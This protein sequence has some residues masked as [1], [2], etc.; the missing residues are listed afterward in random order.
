MSQHPFCLP[1]AT[2]AILLGSFA[3]CL[4]TAT[5]A[6]AAQEEIAVYYN[7]RPPYL[8]S[9]ADGSV[10]GLTGTPAARAFHAAGV[11]FKWVL[12]PTNRQKQ[13]L[14]DTQLPGC[15]VGWF[16]NAERERFAKYTKPIYQDRPTVGL[17]T[18]GNAIPE[19]TPLTMVLAN[20]QL[21]ILVK[22]GYSYGPYIDQLLVG[23]RS[24]L[25]V[26]TMENVEMM[27]MIA[28][29]LA[30][31]MFAAEEE[32]AAL[33]QQAGPSPQSFRILHFTDVPQ[34]ERRYI[35]CNKAVPNHVIQRLNAAIPPLG[36]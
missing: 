14:M 21:R 1:H 3:C 13:A 18:T 34:G 23:K 5:Q 17:A 9:E 28:R 8:V 30:D 35:M 4:L 26:T 11:P 24:G 33:L 20:P 12:M 36:P 29:G 22:D 25:V 6:P 16:K 31:M 10:S 19:R 32:A 7:E 15:A 27:R 2:F